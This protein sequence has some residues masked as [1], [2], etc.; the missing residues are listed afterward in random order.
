MHVYHLS[1]DVVEFVSNFLSLWLSTNVLSYKHSQFLSVLQRSGYS[2]R[3]SPVCVI[4]TF[5]ID[6]LLENTFLH[7]G[8]GVDYLVV[9]RSGC[10]SIAMLGYHVEV[11]I[12]TDDLRVD[13]STEEGVGYIVVP[14]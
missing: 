1:S 14:L 7:I 9:G 13:E 8:I 4:K 6:Q 5:E 3:A 12:G 11:V 2:H 10:S